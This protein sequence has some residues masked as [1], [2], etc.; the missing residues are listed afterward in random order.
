M[1]KEIATARTSQNVKRVKVLEHKDKNEVM[2][3]D[4]EQHHYND[5]CALNH[6]ENASDLASVSDS[7]Q[8]RTD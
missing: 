6:S 1:F 2:N 4:N 3:I 5:S 7:V 8:E